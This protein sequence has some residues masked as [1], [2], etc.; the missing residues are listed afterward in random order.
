M[1]LREIAKVIKGVH[2]LEDTVKDNVKTYKELS[3]LSLEPIS[4]LDE[5]KVIKVN[6]SHNVSPKQLTKEGDVIVSL[7]SPMIACYVE[8]NQE[9]YAVPHYMGIV[10]MKN[11]VKMDSRFIVHFINSARGRRALSKRLESSFSS[12]PT[13]LSLVMLNEVELL[14]GA[15]YLMDRF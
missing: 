5:R 15:N 12:K 8:K 2:L 3:M 11:Y 14:T 13:S 7:Y 4:F 9:G 6:V 10:R 1:K